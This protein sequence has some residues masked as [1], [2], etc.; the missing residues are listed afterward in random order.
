MPVLPPMRPR[1]HSMPQSALL[2]PTSLGQVADLRPGGTQALLRT[3][4]PKAP[5]KSRLR[6]P[7]ALAAVGLAKSNGAAP[8][9]PPRAFVSETPGGRTAMQVTEPERPASSQTFR[10]PPR[11]AMP[12]ASPPPAPPSAREPQV[13]P[14]QPQPPPP[15]MSYQSAGSPRSTPSS[16][17]QAPSPPTRAKAPTSIARRAARDLARVSGDSGRM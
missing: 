2:A 14:F 16:V 7:A 8:P 17:P 11:M 12:P 10:A 13:M 9:A 3:L 6:R 4:E 15:R 5:S 1:V